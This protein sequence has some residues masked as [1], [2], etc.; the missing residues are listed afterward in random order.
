M[1]TH[2]RLVLKQM[3]PLL[4]VRFLA[5]SEEKTSRLPHSMVGLLASSHT[6]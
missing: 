5:L 3:M 2:Q 4:I 6:E 1:L